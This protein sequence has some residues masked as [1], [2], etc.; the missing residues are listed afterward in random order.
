MK[1]ILFL[2]VLIILGSCNSQMNQNTVP[3]DSWSQPQE[4][5]QTVNNQDWP[6]ISE[7]LSQIPDIYLAD[8]NFN[9][10]VTQSMDTC[11][12]DFQ[13]S[14][15]GLGSCDDFLTESGREI[16][17]FSQVTSKAKD[18]DAIEL[19]DSLSE[20]Y[21]DSCKNEVAT[22][23]WV[24]TWNPESC[25]VLSEWYLMQCKN[26]VNVSLA[27]ADRNE[28]LCNNVISA[29]EDFNYEKDFCIQEVKMQIENDAYQ[30]QL[31][32]EQEQQQL[33]ED[34]AVDSSEDDASVESE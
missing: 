11:I 27:I 14:N 2:F 12:S 26:Q 20:N 30:E 21:A 33:L 8:A 3:A 23:L 24:K 10:C 13:F 22:A 28:T 16:C 17:E 29:D 19:C 34:Q 1:H 9:S 4:I 5:S 18:T 15:S 6:N 25:E 31:R 32:V 7:S